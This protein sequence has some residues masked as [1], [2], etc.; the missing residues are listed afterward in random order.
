[1]MQ[2]EIDA[3][4]LQPRAV[5]PHL[6][7]GRS[8]PSAWGDALFGYVVYL[9]FVRPDWPRMVVF[10][11]MSF[12]VAAVFVGFGVLTGSLSFFIGNSGAL[13]DQWRYTM[14]SFATYPPTL[15]QGAVKV[16]LYTLLPAGLASYLPVE[17]LR[18]LSL[19]SALLTLLGAALML[20]TGAGA[21]YAG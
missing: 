2:G 18:S 9:G 12:A 5:L 7:L 4:L 6:V 1:I 14:I 17:A 21:F 16:L 19:S 8:A 15:F 20:M 13:A 11:L 3:W 10:V